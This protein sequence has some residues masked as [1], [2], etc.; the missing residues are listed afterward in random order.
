MEKSLS[1][2]GPRSVT[3]SYSPNTTRKVKVQ[4]KKDGSSAATIGTFILITLH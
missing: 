2:S 1:L 4:L 3:A